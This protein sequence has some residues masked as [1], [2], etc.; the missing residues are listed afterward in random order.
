[1]EAMPNNHLSGILG[2]VKQL[3]I[4][5]SLSAILINSFVWGIAGQSRS[6]EPSAGRVFKTRPNVLPKP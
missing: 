5:I 6:V 2:L 3:T 4:D 1:M